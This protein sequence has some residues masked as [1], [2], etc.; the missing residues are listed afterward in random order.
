[1]ATEGAMAASTLNQTHAAILCLDRD[2]LRAPNRGPSRIPYANSSQRETVGHSP[3]EAGGPVLAIVPATHRLVV[4]LLYG[5]GLR[6]TEAVTLRVKDVDVGRH[7]LHIRDGKGGKDRFTML[8]DALRE[9][10]VAQIDAV[11][12]QHM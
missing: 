3:D 11:R 12:R 6:L 10:M 1:M 8:P 7:R 4:S 2:V 9:A 5:G